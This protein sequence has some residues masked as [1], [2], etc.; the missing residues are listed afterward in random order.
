MQCV[1]TAPIEG[2]TLSL[3][4]YIMNSWLNIDGWAT[5]ADQCPSVATSL[6]ASL[7]WNVAA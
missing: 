4:F 7:M 2:S 6:R 5:E 3:F 1:Y